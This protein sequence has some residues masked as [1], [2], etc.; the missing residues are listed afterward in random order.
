[1]YWFSHIPT[2]WSSWASGDQYTAIGTRVVFWPEKFVMR[3]DM[4]KRR[5]KLVIEFGERKETLENMR[6]ILDIGQCSQ[7]GPYLGTQVLIET[8][9]KNWVV[10]F[11]HYTYILKSTCINTKI[12]LKL[13]ILDSIHCPIYC[14]SFKHLG[15]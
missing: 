2:L 12:G 5:M 10:I 13:R 7:L 11:S 6:K 3:A 8:H 14:K 9:F 4:T 1:M 15:V